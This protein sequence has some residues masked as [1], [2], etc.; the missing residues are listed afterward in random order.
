M[1]EDALRESR[2]LT[3]F[4]TLRLSGPDARNFL[5]GQIS[6]DISALTPGSVLLASCNSAQGRVQSVLWLLQRGDEI[7]LLTSAELLEST[8]ARLKKYVLRAKVKFEPSTLDVFGHLDGQTSM[9]SWTTPLI[10]E[11]QGDANVIHWPGGRQLIVAPTRASDPDE[12]FTRAWQLADVQAG[13]PTLHAQT[14]E[15]FVAQMLNLDVLGGISFEKGCYT[16]QEII[17][18]THYRGSVKRRMFRY[19]VAG[20]VPVSGTRLLAGEEPAGE[21]VTSVSTGSGSELLA[22]V[23]LSQ[24]ERE[25]QLDTESKAVL[26]RLPLPY[27]VDS[28][29]QTG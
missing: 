3:Q 2:R 1:H 14:H 4:G 15:S 7:V 16:G 25:L 8:A 23:Q 11:Q 22:V 20:E 17:A 10:Q 18:R 26:S 13:I 19:A 28:G 29:P 24:V 27:A 9:T 6:A 12:A 21:V 5:Q